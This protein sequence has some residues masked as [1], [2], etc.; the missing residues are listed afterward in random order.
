MCSSGRPVPLSDTTGP[1]RVEILRYHVN[2]C[3]TT[4]EMRSPGRRSLSGTIGWV[5]FPI[6]KVL[7]RRSASDHI[8]TS[9]L[10]STGRDRTDER[11]KTAS[12]SIDR[13][14]GLYQKGTQGDEKIKKRGKAKEAKVNTVPVYPASP[15]ASHIETPPAPNFRMN[16][17][18]CL[19]LLLSF[20][21]VGMR[22]LLLRGLCNVLMLLVLS[23]P[24]FS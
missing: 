19:L 14:G 11:C 6:P 21:V 7:R 18:W 20:F 9:L 5:S 10:T 12:H 22:E 23:V 16:S 2:A 15:A 8:G 1:N 3:P 13:R 17:L 24:C 4:G